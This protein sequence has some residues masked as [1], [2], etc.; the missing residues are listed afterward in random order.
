MPQKDMS[1]GNSK[2]RTSF[3]TPERSEP[4]AHMREWRD[5]KGDR[6]GNSAS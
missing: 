4:A 5:E 2:R 6:F 1:E 3:G